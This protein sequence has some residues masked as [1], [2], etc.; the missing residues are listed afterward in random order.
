M[1]TYFDI[2]GDG[3]SGVVAQVESLLAQIGDAL[4]GVDHLVAV[5]SGKGGVGKSTLTMALAQ[6]LSREGAKA[7]ILDA[8]FNGP[9]Q[10][11]FAGLEGRPWVPGP[12]GL[13]LPRRP[14]GLAVV[15]MGSVFEAARPVSFDSVSSGDEHVWRSTKEFAVLGQLLASVDWGKLDY[16]LFDLPPGAERTVQYADFLPGGTSFVMVTIPSDV[17]RGVVARSVSALAGTGATALGYVENM[18]GYLCPDCGEVKPLF[19]PS[20]TDLDLP[21]L[22]RV[23]FDP[24]LAALCDQG[25]PEGAADLPSL[26]AVARVADNLKGALKGP[27]ADRPADKSAN[28]ASSLEGAHP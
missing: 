10:A 1:K 27:E 6:A 24:Q 16:L 26:A 28:P 25:W 17:S 3:G 14:D 8:D 22:G 20:K 7:A 9:C 12:N 19:P 18:V 4:S 21:L 11:Q 23:P 2:E 5:G 15:S 13:S